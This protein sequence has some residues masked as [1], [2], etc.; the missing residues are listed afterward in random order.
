MSYFNRSFSS[1]NTRSNSRPKKRFSNS[2]F[3]GHGRF[4]GRGRNGGGKRQA[5][6][7]PSHVVMQASVSRPE[8]KQQEEYITINKFTDFNISDE[9]KKNIT[10][11]G[12]TTPTPIQDQAIPHIIDGRDVVGIANTGTGKTAAFLIPL[13]DK[14]AEGSGE[15]VLIIVPTRELALQVRDELR[16][17]SGR[18]RIFSTLC[19]GGSS[20]HRQIES[21]RKG[22]DF[23]I[24]T[25]GRI[26]D[27]N[28]RRKIRFEEF[29][30]I[31]LDEVDRMLDMGFVHEIR[32]IIDRL[33]EERQSLFFSATMTDR[34]REIMKGFL[35]NPVSVSVKTQDTA[36]N[37]N[38]EIL[39]IKGRSKID[40]LHDL[41]I[42]DGF[43]KVLV[44]GRTK[45]GMER[46]SR[47]LQDRGFR[48]NAIHGNKSQGQR[49]R[50]LKEFKTNRLQA[51]IA[52]DVVAR[53]VDIDDITHVINFD[54]PESYADYIHR[55]GRTG[56]ADKVGTAITFVG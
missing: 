42:S 23:V 47:D 17:F 27:L 30:N 21:L 2:K 56:R 29:S 51:L 28:Q 15:K 4:R 32:A 3:S 13:L 52:T 11:R 25:P 19:I 54:L 9:L 20:I 40:M 46:L 16:A 1:S 50:A 6:F 43:E 38:Q 39:K 24:G 34:V 45:R 7:D 12:Y 22:S 14:I 36:D 55:I 41:L 49:Q 26:K 10:T 8:A 35:K 53:G 33:P 37:I 5:S 44:F 31:V 48:V 18:M